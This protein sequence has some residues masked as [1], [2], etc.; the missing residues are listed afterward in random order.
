M[1]VLQQ[2]KETDP[3]V[4][5]QVMAEMSEE[6]IQALSYDWL[7][8]WARPGQMIPP[9]DWFTWLIRT[10]RGWGKTRTG[11]ETVRIWKDTNPIIHFVGRTAADVRDVMIEGE[12]GILAISPKRER[13]LYEPSKRR[14]TW[15]N[16]SIAILFSADEPDV[17]RGPQCH[18][19]WAEE[20]AS[21]KKPDAWDNLIL[22]TRLGP[23]PQIIVTTT[24][25]PTKIIK[26][27]IAEADTIQTTGSTYE[28]VGNVSAKFLDKIK[29]KYEGTR[30][31]SQEIYGN[32]L[33]DVLGALWTYKMIEDLRVQE[34]PEMQRIVVALDPAVTSEKHSD[35]TGIIV[36][37]LGTDGQGYVL[38]DVTGIH[39]PNEWARI[40]I[41]LYNKWQGDRIIGE[42]NN[43]GDLIETVIRGLDKNIPYSKVW[44]SKGKVARAEPI[45]ALYEQ[46]RVHHTGILP[47]L[48][49]EM[50]T[51]AGMQGEKSPNRID[52]LVWALFELMIN[53]TIA[54]A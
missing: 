12:S 52:A 1:N 8:I 28:N 2:I 53:N 36:A 23:N 7:G 26:T 40:A 16:G 19:A 43:G 54:I 3:I 37:G 51:W 31:G 18:K 32:I 13:P 9:G 50:T 20:M 21:W 29:K 46:G 38:E 27:L 24:P 4:L 48:E 44:A 25:R 5:S 41:N 33:E 6:D 39:S 30:L 42:A 10:G 49:T 34:M 11:A 14:L 17:L 47:E 35:E 45:A 15:P 22:G